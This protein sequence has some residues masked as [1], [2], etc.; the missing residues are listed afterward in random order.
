V[1]VTPVTD[2][3]GFLLLLG[4]ASALLL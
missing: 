4:L 1:F 2:A 3:C